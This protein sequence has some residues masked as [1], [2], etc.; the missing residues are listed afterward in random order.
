MAES[1]ETV[2]LWLDLSFDQTEKENLASAIL[3]SITDYLDLM[4][5]S[6]EKGALFHDKA[7]EKRWDPICCGTLGSIATNLEDST[8]TLVEDSADYRQVKNAILYAKNSGDFDLSHLSNMG[9]SYLASFFLTVD[10]ATRNHLLLLVYLA[11]GCSA[12][13]FLNVSQLTDGSSPVLSTS[14]LST[15]GYHDGDVPPNSSDLLRRFRKCFDDSSISFAD[16]LKLRKAFS[17]C[18]DLMDSLPV[19][20]WQEIDSIQV[21]GSVIDSIQ[22]DGSPGSSEP[23]SYFGSTEGVGNTRRS[24]AA[25]VVTAVVTSALIYHH[26]KD[27]VDYGSFGNFESVVYRNSVDFNCRKGMKL[28]QCKVYDGKA[29]DKYMQKLFTNLEELVKKAKEGRGS[30]KSRFSADIPVLFE[31]STKREIDEKLS[32]VGFDPDDFGVEYSDDDADSDI[33]AAETCNC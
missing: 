30:G 28:M 12:F 19:A 17:S 33:D 5:L 9:L 23:S 14:D 6:M 13:G 18:V 24:R 21:D 15:L 10:V 8:S 7:K 11:V 20:K 16:K 27:W 22:V 1:E 26:T 32:I 31:L 4:Q 2:Q 3:G 29:T 25:Y